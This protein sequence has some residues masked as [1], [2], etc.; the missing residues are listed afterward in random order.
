MPFARIVFGSVVEL[1]A[2][3]RG[4][5]AG[6]IEHDRRMV[7]E[8]YRDRDRVVADDS[9]GP[10]GSSHE[11]R[12]V[13]HH[14]TDHAALGREHAVVRRNTEVRA[15]HHSHRADTGILCLLDRQVHRFRRGVVAETVVSVH[16]RRRFGLPHDTGRR[17]RVDRALLDP[18]YVDR[19]PPQ[20]LVRRSAQMGFDQRIGY[21]FRVLGCEAEFLEQRKTEL[22]YALGV[23][24]SGRGVHRQYP[25]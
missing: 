12:A 4:V 14:Y 2:A 25:P 13:R 5:A 24:T 6:H 20:S 3:E 22:T 1:D 21:G 19:K 15:V 16:D 9:L 7:R 8:R 10:S 23:D 18:L 17:L 11:R